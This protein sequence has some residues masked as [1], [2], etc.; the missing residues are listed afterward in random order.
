[1]NVIVINNL[2]LVQGDISRLEHVKCPVDVHGN[3]QK[4]HREEIQVFIVDD[5]PLISWFRL[6]HVHTCQQTE[7]VHNKPQINP[8]KKERNQN[9]RR[10]NFIFRKVR[11]KVEPPPSKKNITGIMNNQGHHPSCHFIAHHREENQRRSH[12]V[13]QHPLVELPLFTPSNRQQLKNRKHVHTQMKHKVNLQLPSLVCRPVRVLLVDL[14][15][16]THTTC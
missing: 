12:K 5:I 14:R 15:A 13:V 9:N 11:F 3:K 1:M 8:H 4:R 2:L 10:N 7:R 6:I 16:A